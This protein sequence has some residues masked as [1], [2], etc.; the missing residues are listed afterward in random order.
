MPK[1]SER[2]RLAKIES[3]Q[4]KLADEAETVRRTLRSSY[5]AI[6]GDLAVERLSERE[7]R[8][9]VGHAIRLGGGTT[10]AAL[11]ALSSAAPK[12]PTAPERRPSDEHGGAARRR[13]A[14]DQGAASPGDGPGL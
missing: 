10:L 3:D 13:P 5:G 12:T 1:M 6:C 7:F 14:P 4:K 9:I 2:E 11:K 8:E